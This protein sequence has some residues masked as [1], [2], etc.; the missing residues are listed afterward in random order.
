MANKA[1][2]QELLRAKLR[3]ADYLAALAEI[4]EIFACQWQTL[5]KN[6]IDSLKVRAEI[7]HKMLGKSLPDL[8]AIEIA[9]E[10]E[11]PVKFIFNTG[12]S[13]SVK[14]V[15]QHY[16]DESDADD[17]TPFTFTN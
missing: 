5:N 9:P 6:Q 2:E 11:S 13:M 4:D 7:N 10:R 3:P 14:E 12:A 8:R 15:Q 16:F 17:A 1:L